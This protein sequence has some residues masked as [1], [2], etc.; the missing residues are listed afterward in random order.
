MFFGIN[1]EIPEDWNL[2]KI[3]DIG[4]I[5]GGGTPDTTNIDY[6]GGNVLWAVPT[7]I[8][9]LK[10]NKIDNTKKKITKEGLTNS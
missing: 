9:K 10:N 2:K 5:N 3:T 6:W 8:T 4:E 7:D 1:I